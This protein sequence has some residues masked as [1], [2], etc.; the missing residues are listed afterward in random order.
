MKYYY[1]DDYIT[2]YCGENREIVSG[3][4]GVTAVVTDPPYGLGFMG[5]DWDHGIPGKHFWELFQ[6]VCLPGA[7]L[8]SFGGTRTFHRLACAIEDAGW[9]I[10]DTIMWVYG[11]GFPKSHDIS[12][13]IDKSEGAE[14]EVVGVGQYNNRRP[15][16]VANTNI[17]GAE[18]GFGSG[19]NI[20]AP[21][22][23]AAK[24]WDGYGTALKPA[25]EP[26]IVAM[27]PV[28]GIF[29]NNAIIYGVAGLNIDGCRVASG[30]EHKRP[31]QPTNNERGVYGAQAAFVPTNAEGRWPANII[32]DGSEEVLDLFPESKSGAMKKHYKY[33]NNGYSLGKPTGETKQIH[34]SNQ[35]SAARFFYCAKAS[36]SERNA[37]LA[38]MPVKNNHPTVKPLKLMQYLLK[39]VTMPENNLILDPFAGSGTTGLAAKKLGL[40]CILI[41][42]EKE[43]CEIAA[44]RCESIKRQPEQLKLIW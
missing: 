18:Y 17:P 11:S 38:G 20:T 1:Q 16:P 33:T 31:P 19:H 29:A 43:H 7:P 2:I 36:K 13:A 5:K 28:D 35:G 30:G 12:K 25:W 21:A 41:D 37:G 8:L 22:T 32:H 40:K 14:R 44:R 27:K 39:L 10:R 4:S 3:L 26:I 34:G 23:P 9:E 42:K 6:S 24:Q 15:S